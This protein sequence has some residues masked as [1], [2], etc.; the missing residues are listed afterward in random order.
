MVEV[1]MVE[2]KGLECGGKMVGKVVDVVV[3]KREGVVF[4]VKRYGIGRGCE[5]GMGWFWD[6]ILDDCL[7]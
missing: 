7:M 4:E 6:I 5:K 1:K 2:G 3:E